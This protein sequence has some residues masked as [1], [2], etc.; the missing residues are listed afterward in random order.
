MHFQGIV[1]N[2]ATAARRRMYFAPKDVTDGVTAETGEAGEQPT[3]TI[4]GGTPAGAGSI[5]TLTHIGGGLYYAEVV[6]S[7]LNIDHGV[8]IGQLKTANTTDS[9]SLNAFEIGGLVAH[10]GAAMKH[11]VVTTHAN[12]KRDIYDSDG[13]TILYSKT[14]VPGAST[15]VDS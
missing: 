4:D 15:T 11:K 8:I 3:V 7:V 12:G 5:G 10:F 6:Q 14:P 9:E 1:K 2:E 13:S